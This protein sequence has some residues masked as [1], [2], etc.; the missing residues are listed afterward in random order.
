MDCPS[1]ERMIRMALEDDSSI[2]QL[3]FDLPAR[4]L[5]AVHE[6]DIPELL[7]R[8]GRLGLGAELV[9]SRTYLDTEKAQASNKT[10]SADESRV[11]KLLL[12]INA[13]MFAIEIVIGWIAESTGLISD[14]LDMFAD[15]AVY[16]ISLYAVGKAKTEKQKAARLSGYFQM[17]LALGAMAEVIRR[18]VMGSEPEG[19]PMIGVAA[20]ALIAN[21][22][23]LFL[24]A[25]HRD[26]EVHMRASWIF[27]TNDVIANCGVIIAGLLVYFTS[28][29]WPDLFIGGIIAAVVFSGAIRI[30]RMAKP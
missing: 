17:A 24:L 8:I 2:K 15:A 3:S 16:A 4:R 9:E 5:T 23:C 25:K 14:S 11:L 28:A 13:T 19:L 7:T 21:A 1:E 26:G 6:G 27:S 10:G 22:T 20:I 18:F 29:T 12:G 30:L